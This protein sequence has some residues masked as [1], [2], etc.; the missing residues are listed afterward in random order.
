MPQSNRGQAALEYLVTYGWAFLAL[1]VV[2]GAMAYF[3]YLSPAKYLPSRCEFG[4]QLECIDYQLSSENPEGLVR[5][6]FRNNFADGIEITNAWVNGRTASLTFIGG[7]AVIAKGN[8]SGEMRV[9]VP[10]DAGVTF[11]EGERFVV[12]M[13]IEF[14]RDL[15]GAPTHN[16]SGEIFA[17]VQ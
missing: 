17:T 3:G 5:L 13:T 8:I 11:L 10:A 2:I 9:D 12:P 7:S 1:L 14:R 6:R 15:S 4:M 16:I